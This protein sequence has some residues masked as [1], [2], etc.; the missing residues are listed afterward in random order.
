MKSIELVEY[1]ITNHCNLNCMGCSHF[2]PLSEQWFAN[3]DE[4]EKDLK[5]LS[6]KIHIINLRLF[7]GEPLLHNNINDF[8]DVSR[9]ILPNTTISILTNGILLL[10]KI[11]MIS[12]HI[13]KNNIV[14][15]LTKYPIKLNYHKIKNV[16]ESI[17]I[18]VKIENDFEKVKKLRH[19]IISKKTNKE[20]ECCMINSCSMQLK[21]GKLYLCPIQAYIDIFNN[22]FNENYVVNSEDIIDI[23]DKNTTD[24]IIFNT[25]YKK[26]SFCEHCSKPVENLDYNISKK[27]KK[28]WT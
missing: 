24:D 19:H 22:Y 11:R 1:H 25:R 14:V 12:S 3:V 15:E 23:Y 27:H 8:M 2:S 9:K 10:D 7:G 21:S 16:L 4:F 5:Q 18:N 26:N 28:E 13:I 20:F 6:S 17:N